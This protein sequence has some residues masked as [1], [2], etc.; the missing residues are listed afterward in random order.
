[1]LCKKT[2]S[3]FPTVGRIISASI[4]K[5]TDFRTLG[6]QKGRAGG[7]GFNPSATPCVRF[8]SHRSDMQHTA[9]L[10]RNPQK[11]TAENGI[12]GSL[13]Q[14]LERLPPRIVHS[15]QRQVRERGKE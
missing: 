14:A 10:F 11:E 13:L 7:I 2:R 1:M 6:K 4:Q 8:T 12:G 3:Q 9:L 15:R 5:G